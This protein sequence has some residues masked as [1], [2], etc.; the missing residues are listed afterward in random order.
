MKSQQPDLKRLLI[1]SLL[2]LLVVATNA[3]CQD[4]YDIE[5]INTVELIFAESNWDEI[6]DSLRLAGDEDRLAAT[7]IINGE[8]FDSV[9]VRYKGNSSYNPMNVKNPLNIKLDYILDDQLLEGYGTLKLANCFKDPSFIREAVSYEIG[10]KYMAASQSNF[11]N[12]HINGELIG[13]YS[14][15]QDVDKYFLRTHFSSDEVPAT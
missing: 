13:L 7:A 10:R 12:V 6:L 2:F 8:Q 3:F 15:V 1:Y 11:A 4:F 5:T 14:S 9:G